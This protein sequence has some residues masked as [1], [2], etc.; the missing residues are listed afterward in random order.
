MQNKKCKICRKSASYTEKIVQKKRSD[1][2]MWPISFHRYHITECCIT[3]LL[4]NFN[5]LRLFKTKVNEVCSKNIFFLFQILS[6]SLFHLTTFQKACRTKKKLRFVRKEHKQ[7]YFFLTWVFLGEYPVI[8]MVKIAGCLAV[9]KM[10][11]ILPW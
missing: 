8:E 5:T 10:G 3:E 6:F 9:A 7:V 11:P 4:S 2:F 1:V